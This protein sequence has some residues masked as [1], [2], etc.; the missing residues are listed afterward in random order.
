MKSFINYSKNRFLYS[1]FKILIIFLIGFLFASSRA[2]AKEV[3]VGKN[4]INPD[5]FTTYESIITTRTDNS[6]SFESNGL[7]AQLQYKITLEKN[8]YYTI[9]YDFITTNS[10]FYPYVQVNGNG[11]WQTQVTEVYGTGHF[12]Y[13]F[14]TGNYDYFVLVF[15]IS[16]DTSIDNIGT[17]SNIQLEKGTTATDYEPYTGYE[18]VSND[19]SNFSLTDYYMKFSYANPQYI[20]TTESSAIYSGN[21]YS[22]YISLN[23]VNVGNFYFYNDIWLDV[24]GDFKAGNTYYI[25][26][27][28][29]A[30][31]MNA[32]YTQYN[33]PY[34]MTGSSY[35]GID[36]KDFKATFQ[37]SGQSGVT[38]YYVV[39][40][41]FTPTK[42]F[43]TARLGFT[44]D[45]ITL[46]N[47]DCIYNSFQNE[48]SE[49][50]PY[51][52]ASVSFTNLSASVKINAENA[53]V[54]NSNTTKGILGTVKAIFSTITNLPKN[55]A[56]SIG[57]FFTA[58]G[59]K[60]GGF[61]T[62]LI[63]SMSNFFS[64]LGN[65][66]GTFFDNLLTGILDGL[67]ALFIP[68]DDYFTNW[69]DDFT[70]AF[71]NKLGFLTYPFDLFADV[72]NRFSNLSDSSGIIHIPEVKVPNFDFVIIEDQD[73]SLKDLYDY[74]NIRVIHTIYLSFIDIMLIISL[75]NLALKQFNDIVGNGTI[76]F[77]TNDGGLKT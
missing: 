32:S 52:Y 43:S 37:N 45:Y 71:K 23:S 15:A 17:L 60:I 27:R 5:N 18:E 75:V 6:I 73:F 70:T 9:S 61:F 65:R 22:K 35:S 57:G 3:G 1:L 16:A 29:N 68:S 12:Y 66:I 46:Y 77:D 31:H 69:I 39:T 56:N 13:S 7:Y 72:I 64:D 14:N 58:L 20:G 51:T 34:M 62:N 42:D 21:T 36:Y 25:N 76:E 44:F 24:F 26:Y 28:F 19:N 48:G 33:S 10:S 38:N 50:S 30:K 4:L 59:D 54:D 2:S 8:T 11:S 74:E 49:T 55:I 47:I 40:Y 63:N 41:E 53:I 67:K